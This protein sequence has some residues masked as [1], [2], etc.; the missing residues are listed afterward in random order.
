MAKKRKK[1]EKLSGV[2]DIEALRE[3]VVG[4][5]GKWTRLALESGVNYHTITA[6]GKGAVVKLGHDKVKLLQA[7]ER[8]YAARTRRESER[9]A[10]G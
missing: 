7:H 6:F 10:Q 3:Y 2:E 5:R 8:K 9:A 1:P 4:Q